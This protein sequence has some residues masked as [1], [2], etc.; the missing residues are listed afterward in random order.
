MSLVW[1]NMK[2]KE[3][4]RIKGTAHY[5]QGQKT[6]LPQPDYETIKQNHIHQ[7]QNLRN[8]VVREA[9]EYYNK[10][11]NLNK[12]YNKESQKL[13]EPNQLKDIGLDIEK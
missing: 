7:D 12:F 10:N 5:A 6:G 4:D 1:D 11:N 13:N 2:Q 8:N 3:A 9:G